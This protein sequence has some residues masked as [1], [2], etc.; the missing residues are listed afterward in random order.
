MAYYVGSSFGAGPI[1][2]DT[3]Q[4]NLSPDSLLVLSTGGLLP[5]VFDSFNGMLDGAGKAKAKL[6]IPGA[7][8]LAGLKI[9]NAFITLDLT[10][11]SGI[12]TISNTY[13]FTIQP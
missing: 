6:N 10:A 8:V 5:A 9:H 1:P 4:I 3:R 11:P 12:L 7:A 13:A 2:V